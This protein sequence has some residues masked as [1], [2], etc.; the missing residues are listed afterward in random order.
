MLIGKMQG[1]KVA[2][3]DNFSHFTALTGDTYIPTK[4][5]PFRIQ[6]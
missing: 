5:Q 1:R 2:H 4:L 3:N 6:S